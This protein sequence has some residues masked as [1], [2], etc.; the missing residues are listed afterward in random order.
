MQIQ[1]N[2]THTLIISEHPVKICDLCGEVADTKL[3]PKKDKEIC[4]NCGTRSNEL[5]TEFQKSY[6]FENLRTTPQSIFNVSSII[7]INHNC[8][9]YCKA[10]YRDHPHGCPNFGVHEECPPKVDIVENIFDMGKDL[11]FVVEEFDLKSHVEKMRLKHPK[12]SEFQLR[13]LLYWQGGVR[14]RLTFKTLRFISTFSDT[15]NIIY[16]LLPEAMGVMV[17]NTALKARIPIQKSPTDKIFKIAL[18]GYRKD[19]IIETRND[20]FA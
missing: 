19:P 3:Q 12:W 13:N 15:T 10:P 7:E 4:F 2:S 9:N 11:F 20:Y 14:K 17:I 6:K 18:V 8:R 5:K 1:E 16:T